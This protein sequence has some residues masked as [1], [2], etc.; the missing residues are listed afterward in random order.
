[1]LGGSSYTAENTRIMVDNVTRAVS[2]LAGSTTTSSTCLSA[3]S[4][5][6]AQFNLS[7]PLR[8]VGADGRFVYTTD[9]CGI[10]RIDPTTGA[11]SS[12]TTTGSFTSNRQN[13]AIAGQHMYVINNSTGGIKKID[14]A[15]GASTTFP[16]TVGTANVGLAG[17]IAADAEHIWVINGPTLYKIKATDGTATI[18]TAQGNQ[19]ITGIAT[20][21]TKLYTTDNTT[22]HKGIN[23]VS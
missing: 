14:L 21:N 13:T 23:T 4:G 12:L 16:V 8:V 11:V 5:A 1:V 3:A 19:N 17:S 2:V 20:D 18:I 9:G 22:T 7:A 6:E 15:S 10:R